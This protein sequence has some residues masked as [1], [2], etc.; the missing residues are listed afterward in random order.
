MEV[1]LGIVCAVRGAKD[2]DEDELETVFVCLSAA[3]GKVE[4][5]WSEFI[6]GVGCTSLLL[7]TLPRLLLLV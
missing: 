5:C 6:G 2:E 3:L 4:A 1:L 7:L